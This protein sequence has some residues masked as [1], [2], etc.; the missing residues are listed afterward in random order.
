MPPCIFLDRDIHRCN[1][2]GTKFGR[3]GKVDHLQKGGGQGQDRHKDCGN[4][5]ATMLFES[6]FSQTAAQGTGQEAD[7]MIVSKSH[8]F[9]AS[10]RV[11]ADKHGTWFFLASIVCRGRTE[12]LRTRTAQYSELETGRS[13]TGGRINLYII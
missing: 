4:S 7:Q 12:G 11:Q 5:R 2:I 6:F 10:Q 1:Q 3:L 13:T 9:L 8:L